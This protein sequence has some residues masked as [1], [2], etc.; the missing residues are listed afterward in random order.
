MRDV[1][2][3]KSIVFEFETLIILQK[4]MQSRNYNISKACNFLIKQGDYLIEK[5]KTERKRQELDTE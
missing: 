5:I 1:K 2:T 3:A 4:T